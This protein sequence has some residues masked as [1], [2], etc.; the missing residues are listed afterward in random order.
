[1]NKIYY[2]FLM[3]L[4]TMLNA[5]TGI[6][7][8]FVIVD[9]GAST[10]YDCIANGATTD[11]NGY[12]FGTMTA[13]STL[14]LNGGELKT[15]KSDGGNITGA[16][17]YYRVY[18]TGTTAPSFTEIQMSWA[19]D[20]VDG[21]SNNQKWTETAAAVNLLSGL[22]AG[23]YTLEV[24][25]KAT[26]NEGDIYD[27]NSSANYSAT[28][29]YATS[30]DLQIGNVSISPALPTRIEQV[31]ITLD[32]TGTD[33]ESA[34]AVYLHSGVATDAPSSTAFSTV[35]GNWGQADGVGEMTS[36]GSNQWQIVLTDIDTYYSLTDDDDAF[37][38]NFLFRNADGT[39]LEDN[40]GA[41][42]HADIDPGDYFLLTSPDYSPYLTASG[43]SF[44]IEANASSS[45]SWTLDELN[46]DGTTMTADVN[47]Q[48]SLQNYSF[49]HTLNDTDVLHYFKLT[50]D[51]GSLSKSKTFQVKTHK[52]PTV[53]DLPTGVEKGI[54]YN[55]DG[56]VTFVLHTPVSTTYGYY[57]YSGTSCT[58]DS[59]TAAT[60]AK[61]SVYLIGDFN[62]WEI[63]DD[64]LLNRTTDSDYWWITLSSSQ[65]TNLRVSGE[66]ESVFQYLV[67]GEIRIGDPYT[68]QVSDPDDQYI[69]S[70]VYPDLISYPTGETTGRASV[71]QLTTPTDY[72][73]EVPTFN[74][75]YER[76]DLN[77]YELHFRDFTEEGTY[78]AA[79]A[80]LD[81]IEN[82]GVNCIHVMP[83]SEFEGNS[84]WGYNPNYYFAADKAYGTAD[85]LKEFIDEAHKR[86][87]AV[88]NDLVLNHAFYSNPNAML[89]WDDTN[90]RPATD[91]PWFNAEHKGIYSTDGHWGAD[92]NHGSNHTRQ[93]VDDIIN[94]WMNE[95]KFDGFR[96]DF[97]KGFTQADQDSSDPW[98][99]SYDACRIEILKRMANTVWANT[100]GSGASPYVIFEH[101]AND[102][103]DA[104][105]ADEGI[106]M[107]SGS[108][109]QDSWLEMAMGT[110]NSS[111]WSSVYSSR[112]F[113]YANYMSYMES[114]DEERVGYKVKMWGN[115]KPAETDATYPNY[116]SN[117][118]KLVAA[119]NL[120][121]P[122]PR[123]V[124]Q[125]GELGYDISI[126]ENGRTG[127]KSSAWE[128]GY[129][130]ES[131][132]QEIYNLYRHTFTFRNKYS[133][134]SD[135]D[136]GNIGSTTDWN[137]RFSLYDGS[138]TQ[139]IAVGDFDTANDG[140]VSPGYFQTGTWYKYNGDPA[141]D[142]TPYTV[143][144]TTDTFSLTTVDP[145]YIL[146][147]ADIIP[148]VFNVENQSI[149]T[150]YCDFT[151]T[152]TSYD[153][154]AGTWT[155]GATTSGKAADNSG[156]LS[157]LLT[158][159][160]GTTLNQ[161][162]LAGQSLQT[163]E[164]TLVWEATDPSGNT[165]SFTQTITLNRGDCY[166]SGVSGTALDSSVLISTLDRNTQ[167]T[168][169]KN[170][171]LV[172][173][174]K[175][176]GFVITTI[177]S[178][179]TTAIISNPV[180]GMLVFDENDNCLKIY[181]GTQ[182]GCLR[183]KAVPNP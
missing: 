97:T 180:Q 51:F 43:V 140:A 161:S 17:L 150:D 115:D 88:V 166:K 25:F 98:A 156:T 181:D 20:N 117:R 128:L 91:N 13:T 14:S 129:D 31:T 60:A 95:F 159:L 173:E 160:N 113:T 71:V 130:Q 152:D 42:Y 26:S 116:F 134:Y 5:G 124:W 85:E 112:G 56:S 82:L 158:S 57:G 37:A 147:N 125:F 174:S 62:N 168:T 47:T 167:E 139:V 151:I 4:G 33:L 7:G 70:T 77:V 120:L 135:V 107:W 141:V 67:D 172:L 11:F 66:D 175:E 23:N 44:S 49:S 87:I 90:N 80:K 28:F 170:G 106:L 86:G 64:Y 146:S 16:Y 53:A 10:Y 96:F 133:L 32:A 94:Y 2:L 148:P 157:I 127:E 143:S 18:E 9:D 123:M 29:S 137:R 83:V 105:L 110:T 63:E 149:D 178:G 68:H 126:D 136:Y 40:S 182:W 183:Q 169:K 58:A 111:F 72:T 144:N 54:N 27:N 99:S 50:A 176:K 179:Q 39:E 36:L 61:T 76:N 6:Y 163:G 35:V 3:L 48:S 30:S 108:G 165:T 164:N 69:S 109:P 121:L 103:E 79:T 104:L 131:E 89:Y 138:S 1:M 118:T 122:G 154:V 59:S 162:S 73:W 46:S 92:W 177:P 84:S 12:D 153:V 75:T 21:S 145:V 34:T 155:S 100:S 81:Y 102:D 74:R 119:F 24:Y 93:M 114:H 132:R 55:S 52:T 38:L 19:E 15:W 65:L 101:L 142:G 171:L 78:A 22:S 45:V 41:N 8:S